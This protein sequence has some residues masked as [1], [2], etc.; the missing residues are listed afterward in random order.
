MR[1]RLELGTIVVVGPLWGVE[2]IVGGSVQHGRREVG[3][4]LPEMA[5]LE[6]RNLEYGCMMSVAGFSKEVYEM[7]DRQDSSRA[8]SLL[9]GWTFANAIGW[10]GG[11]AAGM[12][13]TTVA[14]G[15]PWLNEDRFFA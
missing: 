7:S 12:W 11:L 1:S 13:L 3:T 4:S 10:A 5:N 8:W 14:A 9:A 6:N 2:G 15:L